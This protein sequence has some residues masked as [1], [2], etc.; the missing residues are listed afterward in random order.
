MPGSFFYVFNG[1]LRQNSITYQL[2]I[3]EFKNEITINWK[4]S[5]IQFVSSLTSYTNSFNIN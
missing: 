3:P 4:A 1:E 5:V 2:E